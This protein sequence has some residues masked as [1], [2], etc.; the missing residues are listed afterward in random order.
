MAFTQLHTGRLS[1]SASTD[2]CR[3]G[4][5]PARFLHRILRMVDQYCPHDWDLLS[6][7]CLRRHFTVDQ[8]LAEL[9]LW[10]RQAA[11]CSD[12]LTHDLSWIVS[13]VPLLSI[14]FE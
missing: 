9:Q 12:N 2:Y 11:P 4:G 8:F 3:F 7:Q 1:T 6:M 13:R 5:N 14:K 10:R